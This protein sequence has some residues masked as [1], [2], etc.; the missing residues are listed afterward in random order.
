ML[1]HR[2]KEHGVVHLRNTNLTNDLGSM[3]SWALNVMGGEY[4][5]TGGANYRGTIEGEENVYDT[6]APGEAHIHYHHEMAYMHSTVSSLGLFCGAAL[7]EGG[8]T[9]LSDNIAVPDPK[10]GRH[11]HTLHTSATFTMVVWYTR[12]A[13]R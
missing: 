1:S 10:I 13:H 8:S 2:F 6:G 5:Y 9:F 11:S 7:P 3:R 4:N 12:C